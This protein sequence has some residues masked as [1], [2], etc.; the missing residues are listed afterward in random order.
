MAQQDTVKRKTRLKAGAPLGERQ[1]IDT[2]LREGD[3]L[4]FG[5]GGEKLRV[6]KISSAEITFE[7]LSSK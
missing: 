5:A 7:K 4:S 1:Q 6:Q 3:S 2:T